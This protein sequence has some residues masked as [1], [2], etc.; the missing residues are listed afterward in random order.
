MN[1]IE[2]DIANGRVYSL[3]DLSMKVRDHMEDIMAT[4]SGIS[5]KNLY[6]KIVSP[7]IEFSG[8]V[9]DCPGVVMNTNISSN[10]IYLIPQIHSMILSTKLGTYRRIVQKNDSQQQWSK[11]LGL[12]SMLLI[13]QTP[14]SFVL[15]N[16]A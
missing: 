10:L 5:T 12:N 4:P 16:A 2:V 13:P 14:S 9:I 8:I 15:R 3:F 1:Q 7:D 6:A 11:S